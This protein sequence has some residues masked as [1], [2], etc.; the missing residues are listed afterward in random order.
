MTAR[1]LFSPLY[2]EIMRLGSLSYGFFHFS[3]NDDKAL[4]RIQKPRHTILCMSDYRQDFN[5]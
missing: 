4:D 2:W 5:W 3:N 1:E